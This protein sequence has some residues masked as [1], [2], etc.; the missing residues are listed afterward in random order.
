MNSFF[1][2]LEI[3]REEILIGERKALGGLRYTFID[4]LNA[5]TYLD[6]HCRPRWTNLAYGIYGHIIE[7]NVLYSSFL[8]MSLIKNS[9]KFVY[10]G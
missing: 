2:N 7:L 10:R 5:E 4:A 3:P 6:L 8:D 1:D 9:E